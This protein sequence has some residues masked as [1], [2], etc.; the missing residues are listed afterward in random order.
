MGVREESR[1]GLELGQPE[2]PHRRRASAWDCAGG[3]RDFLTWVYSWY[4]SLLWPFTRLQKTLSQLTIHADSMC[5]P[6]LRGHES[7]RTVWFPVSWEQLLQ[8]KAGWALYSY[9]QQILWCC[10]SHM[11]Y[12]EPFE[13]TTLLSLW[14]RDHTLLVPRRIMK[15]HTLH[16]PQRT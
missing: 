8:H 1:G 2:R 7:I 13:F 9:L 5:L 14:P 3:V 16:I 11:D 10:L 4:V 6:A 12:V 15:P